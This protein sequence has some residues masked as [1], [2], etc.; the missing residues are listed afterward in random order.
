MSVLDVVFGDFRTPEVASFSFVTV[1]DVLARSS[2]RAGGW[3]LWSESGEVASAG[4]SDWVVVPGEVDWRARVVFNDGRRWLISRAV[5]EENGIILAD[6]SLPLTPEQAAARASD[7]ARN[8][9]R[10]GAQEKAAAAGRLKSLG[11]DLTSRLSNTVLAV[12]D[13]IGG[14]GNTLAGFA[15][16]AASALSHLS[17]GIVIFL[18][19]AA[20]IVLLVLRR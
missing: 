7:V 6:A 13:S 3:L 15:G 14:I 18:A 4:S 10:S 5:A 2:M 1:P 11:G 12:G 16:G 17:A 9:H 19:V 8:V 20:A